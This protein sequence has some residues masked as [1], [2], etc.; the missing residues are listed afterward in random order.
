[1]THWTALQHQSTVADIWVRMFACHNRATRRPDAHVTLSDSRTGVARC[2]MK[3]GGG[4]CGSVCHVNSSTHY[5]LAIQ[6]PAKMQLDGNGC[7]Y[8]EGCV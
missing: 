2:D 3:A 7:S 8:W 6:P 5:V 1:M 4:P